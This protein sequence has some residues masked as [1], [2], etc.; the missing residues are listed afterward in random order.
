MAAIGAARRREELSCRISKLTVQSDLPSPDCFSIQHEYLSI[1]PTIDVCY[2]T[3]ATQ[4]NG[5]R[6]SRGDRQ[7]I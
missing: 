3:H 2:N 1:G 4:N 7:K 6:S 5:M